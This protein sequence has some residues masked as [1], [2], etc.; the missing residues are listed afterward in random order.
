MLSGNRF[1]TYAAHL[2]ITDRA[3][4]RTLLENQRSQL[5][6]RIKVLLLGAYGVAPDQAGMIDGASFEPSRRV[7]PLCSGLQLNPPV[8]ASLGDALINLLDQALQHQFPAHPDF[9]IS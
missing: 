1:D 8:G 2:S 6:E 3:Q 4:A 5:T 7:N 9:K